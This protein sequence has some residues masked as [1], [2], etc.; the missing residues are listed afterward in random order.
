[1]WQNNGIMEW[2]RSNGPRPTKIIML[3]LRKER[4]E[5][6]THQYIVLILSDDCILRLDRRG[7]EDNP[8]DAMKSDGSESIDTVE[9]VNSLSELD[10]TSYTL[11]EVHCQG[12]DVDLSNIIKICFGIHIDDKARHYTLQRFNCYFFSWTILVATARHAVPWETL[13]F[14]SPWETL[15]E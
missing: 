12:G 10:K 4:S 11:A 3:Q 15:S 5:P 14:D 2:H 9:D 7:D 8:M 13:P 6:F 1:D